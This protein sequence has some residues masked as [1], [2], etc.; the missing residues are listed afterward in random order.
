MVREE[1]L[2]ELSLDELATKLRVV[3][4]ALRARRQDKFSDERSIRALQVEWSNITHR[5]NYLVQMKVA[6]EF[7]ESL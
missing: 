3:G 5:I 4:S 7:E 2:D 1:P 6:E